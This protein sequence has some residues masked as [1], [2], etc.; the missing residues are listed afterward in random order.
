[1]FLQIGLFLI[2]TVSHLL[3]ACFLLRFYSFLFRININA[4]G[5]G[6][7][8]FVFALTDWAV[9]PLRRFIPRLSRVDLPSLLPALM[10]QALLGIFKSWVLFGGI[11]GNY[12]VFFLILDT[13]GLLVSL[14]IGL[15]IIQA[16]LSWIQPQS[17]IQY[18]LQQFTQPLLDPIRRLMPLVGGI[19]LSPLVALLILQIISMV[20]QSLLIA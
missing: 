16:V 1:M 8:R 18:V 6:I 10:M 4:H 19:D 5:S 9:L 17:G 14:M 13:L 2:Q 3:T 7:G 15:L 20:I 11:Q 12:I